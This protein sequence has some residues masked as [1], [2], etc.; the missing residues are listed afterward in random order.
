MRKG[1]PCEKKFLTPVENQSKFSEMQRS[2]FVPTITC[3]KQH[4]TSMLFQ[5]TCANNEPHCDSFFILENFLRAL[6]FFITLSFFRRIVSSIALRLNI[7]SHP[8]N[9]SITKTLA[10]AER[11]PLNCWIEQESIVPPSFQEV[12]VQIFI[13]YR[14]TTVNQKNWQASRYTPPSR[15]ERTFTQ[16]MTSPDLSSAVMC[17]SSCSKQTRIARTPSC[18]V[19]S[20]E[21]TKEANTQFRRTSTLASSISFLAWSASP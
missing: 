1:Y 6:I 14:K 12:A 7:C 13:G 18:S 20:R 8:R 10:K 16:D 15:W 9:L 19:N 17:K 5:Q 21:R 11:K 4:K 2:E 3:W